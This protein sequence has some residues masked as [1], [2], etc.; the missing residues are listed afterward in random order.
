MMMKKTEPETSTVSSAIS[1]VPLAS[2]EHGGLLQ[3]LYRAVPDYWALYNLPSAPAGQAAHD[4]AEAAQ[5][6]GRTILGILRP[7]SAHAAGEVQEAK[8]APVELVG[9]VDLRLHYPGDGIAS[10]GMILIAE[11]VRRQG[12]GTAAWSYVEPWL[13]R[14]AGMHKAR[15]GVEQFNTP[16]L[17][18]FQSIGFALTGQA[19]R[20]RVGEKFV[21]LLYMEKEIA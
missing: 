1:L 6:P 7:L 10:L 17:A 21:R 11:A 8:D 12:I 16:A 9:M 5:T 19:A 13:A 18:F 20:H 4:L 14:Q 15:L 2:G 3:A